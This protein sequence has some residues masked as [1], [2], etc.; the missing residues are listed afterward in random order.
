MKALFF[1]V[2]CAAALAVS[3]NAAH[4]AN[5]V[6]WTQFRARASNN[7]VIGGALR[8]QW[9]VLTDGRISASPTF[10]HGLVFVGTNAGTLYA[11]RAGDGQIF[12]KHHV[13]NPLMSSPLLYRGLVIAGEG[14]A[15]TP[16]PKGDAPAHVGTGESAIVAFDER[17]GAIRWRTPLRGSGMPTPAIVGGVLVHHDGSGRITGMDPMTG[18]LLYERN[19][20]SIASMSA[21]LPVQQREFVTSGVL[22]NAVLRVKAPNGAVVWSTN[23]FPKNASGLGDCPMAGDGERLYG[24]YVA[25]DSSGAQPAIGKP[26]RAH[27]YALDAKTG[28]LLW[29]LPL[30]DGPL[31]IRNEAG[32]PVVK[33]GVLYVG[34]ATSPWVNAIDAK[35]GRVLWKKQ[36]YGPVKGAIAVKNGV[37]YFGDLSGSLWALN[38]RTG[39]QLGVKAMP[40]SFNVGSPIIVGQTL[41]IGSMTG[42]LYAVPLDA[43]RDGG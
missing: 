24:E 35:T 11:I 9:E 32:I 39:A 19:V 8:V 26:V 5:G 37:V 33:D 16:H 38:A 21:V 36:I 4:A 40:T 14:N 10:A 31:P 1:S 43:I 2:A 20:H 15:D 29:D 42:S 17:T 22:S 34:G 41:F 13:A 27:A 28:A 18:R 3:A 7:A 6:H 30:E 25:P 23:P 12:W